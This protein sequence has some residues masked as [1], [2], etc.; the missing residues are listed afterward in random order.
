MNMSNDRKLSAKVIVSQSIAHF[1]TQSIWMLESYF[2]LFF[3]TDVIKI[4]ALAS[5][6][7]MLIA[8]IWDALNDPMMGVIC[9]KTR[10]KEGKARF[11]LKY[12]SIPAGICIALTYI[13]PNIGVTGRIAW[14]AVTYLLMGMAKTAVGIPANTLAATMTSNRLERVKL[15]QY[16]GIVGVLP[17]VVVPALTMPLVR[18]FGGDNMQKGFAILAILLGLIVA[19]SYLLIYW[20]SKGYDPDTSEAVVSSSDKPKSSPS[21]GELLKAALTDKYCLLASLNY[22][23]YLLMAGIMTSTL[24]YYFRYNLNNDGLMGVYSSVI[25]VAALLS[26]LIVRVLCKKFGN[27]MTCLIGGVICVIAF[28]PRIITGDQVFP[29]FVVSIA[30]AGLGSGLVSN[31]NRQCILDATTWSK[32]RTG[33]DNSAVIMSVY[34]F[35]Q[36]FG[37]AASTVI[38]AGLLALFHY[39]GGQEPTSAVLKLFYVENIIIPVTIAVMMIV[40]LSILNRM[41]KQMVKELEAQKAAEK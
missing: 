26:I 17:N 31:V 9:D 28:I 27:A 33:V 20:G 24:I 6:V 40:L 35:A 30:L 32:L 38:A 10:S 14:V 1:G 34:S 23:L 37:T 4:P 18:A 41:E 2:L 11:W 25:A 13:C 3:Y 29:V 19:G 15:A 8:R 5:T 12:L 16:T 7:I 39:E 22:C 36:K 21:A